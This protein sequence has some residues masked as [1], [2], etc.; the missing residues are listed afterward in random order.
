VNYGLLEDRLGR[1]VLDDVCAR[2]A[3]AGVWLYMW[4]DDDDGAPPDDDD[5]D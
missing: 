5:R 4:L 3:T 1:L 2:V